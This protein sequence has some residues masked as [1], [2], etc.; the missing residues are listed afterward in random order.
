MYAFPVFS[1]L[2]RLIVGL[3]QYS[4]HYFLGILGVFIFRK[5][6]NEMLKYGFVLHSS[7]LILIALLQHSCLSSIMDNFESFALCF[8]NKFIILIICLA[9]PGLSSGTHD[10]LSSVP[11]MGS[12]S[13]TMDRTQAP[14]IGNTDSASGPLGSSHLHF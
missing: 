6:L 2:L 14:C 13:L 10:L 3:F 8:F 4:S 7:C 12:S 1:P 9:A 11:L 5:F